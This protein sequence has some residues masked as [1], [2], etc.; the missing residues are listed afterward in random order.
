MTP[1]SR[2]PPDDCDDSANVLVLAAQADPEFGEELRAILRLPRPR[3][4]A[5][6]NNALGAMRLRRADPVLVQAVALLADDAG[7]ALV[8]QRL[9]QR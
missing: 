9:E 4:E 8:R 1:S 7:V 2:V 6:I 3:R 5:M